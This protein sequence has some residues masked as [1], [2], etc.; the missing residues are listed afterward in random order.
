MYKN[1]VICCL[2]FFVSSHSYA[3]NYSAKIDELKSQIRPIFTQYLGKDWSNK[4]LGKEIDRIVLPP[5]PSLSNKQQSKVQDHEDDSN[6]KL[7][8]FK[9]EQI[10][11]SHILFVQEV[12]EATRNE[13]VSQ[14]ELHKW[15]NILDQGSSREGVYRALVLD[16]TYAK[17][18]QADNPLS[19]N[20]KEFAQHFFSKFLNQRFSEE[21]INELN[22]YT[23]KRIAT[24]RSLE[25]FDLLLSD[26]EKMS[27]WYAVLSSELARDYSSGFTRKIRKEV[28]KKFHK[29]WALN[30]PSQFV[31]S[32]IIIKL[33]KAFNTFM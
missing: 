16:M 14:E 30:A 23:I 5:I 18:E 11:A 2:L 19:S 25:V 32:E 6:V 13:K 20:A 21:S 15:F 4:I 24:E 7:K 33:H 22:L 3:F 8:N 26:R 10:Q 27:D 29:E 31:K 1:F 28:S 12:Y 17:L 9:K